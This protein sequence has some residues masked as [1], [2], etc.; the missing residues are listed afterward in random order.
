MD[1]RT[2]EHPRPNHFLLH[3][4]DTHLIA[5]DGELYGDVDSAARL[6]QIVDEIEASGSHPE[7]IVVTGDVADRGEPGAYAR[8][9]RILEPAS[10]RLGAQLIWAMGNH[11][12]R[13]A[14]RRELFG[15][16]PTDRPV[17]FVYDVNGLRVITLDTSV[18]GHHYGELTSAQLD[19]LAEELSVAAPHGTILALHHPPVPSVQDL[20]VLVELRDQQALAEVVE[21]SDIISI[22]GGHLHYSTTSQFA[23]IPVSVASATCYTQDLVTE[24][25]GTR[26]RDGAQSFNLVHVYGSTVVHSVVPIGH[27]ATVGERVAPV[28]VAERLAAAGVV[29]PAAVEPQ[30]VTSSIPVFRDEV[31]PA[32][33][34]SRR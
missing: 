25:G 2:A 20:T 3:L 16:Q 11:D 10:E 27:Y 34:V 7:A 15:L 23:G 33:P 19:W 9:R 24:G 26:G 31:V 5:A 22:I 21:G 6:Q 12:E 29:I 28:Q 30:P 32:S 1:I 17:D 4:S 14:F 18:P 8:V 13:G